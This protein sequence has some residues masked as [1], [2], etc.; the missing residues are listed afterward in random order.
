MGRRYE[1]PIIDAHHHLWDI[2]LGRH[3]WITSNDG[4]IKALGDIAFLRRNYLADDY[5]ADVGPQNVVKSVY[6]EAVWDRTRPPVE[7]VEWLDRL[8]RPPGIAA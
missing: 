7:E 2:G 4:A 8:P 3:P 6:I 5:I 1:G